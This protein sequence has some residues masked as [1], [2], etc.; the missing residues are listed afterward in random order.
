MKGSHGMYAV[1]ASALEDLSDGCFNFGEK[2]RVGVRCD[3]DDLDVCQFQGLLSESSFG[4][5]W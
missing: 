5:R 4:K 1:A 3:R 2:F